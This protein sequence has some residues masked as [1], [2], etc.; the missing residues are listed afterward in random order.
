MIEAHGFYEGKGSPFR[1][2]PERAARVLGL[3]GD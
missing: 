3:A 1:V 2:D